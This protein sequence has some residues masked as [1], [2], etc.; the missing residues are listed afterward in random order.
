MD[1]QNAFSTRV[2]NK[3]RYHSIVAKFV[4]LIAWIIAIMNFVWVVDY[5]Y[6]EYN[7]LS[8]ARSQGA[9]WLTDLT[10]PLMYLR[11]EIALLINA[12][13]LQF[14]TVKSLLVSV[15]ALGWVLLEYGVWYEKSLQI[16]GAANIS[17]SFYPGN[18]YGATRWNIFILIMSVVFFGWVIKA[19]LK[20]LAFKRNKNRGTYD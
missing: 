8:E 20:E 4:A 5:L 19:I 3:Y 12:A 9:E 10:I 16:K 17:E 2:M 7:T 11:M 18:L 1:S 15:L 13:G 14:R 6:K